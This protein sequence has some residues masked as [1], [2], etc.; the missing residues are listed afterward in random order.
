[1]VA[2]KYRDGDKLVIECHAEHF[3]E[4]ISSFLFCTQ[5]DVNSISANIRNEAMC[6]TGEM[7]DVRLENGYKTN[8]IR[9]SISKGTMPGFPFTMEFKSKNNTSFDI[10][11]V[12]HEK[13]HDRYY[14]IPIING[15]KE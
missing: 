8:A 15:R 6:M 10:E 1:M 14:P 3:L 4:P 12:M 7:N 5:Q 13:S 2:Y 9:R 11:I